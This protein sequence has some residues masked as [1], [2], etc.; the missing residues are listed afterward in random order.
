[1]TAEVRS[2]G[3]DGTKQNKICDTYVALDLETTGLNPKEDSIIE[4]G[5]VKVIGGKAADTY[6]AFVSPAKQLSERVSKLTGITQKDLEQAVQPEQAVSEILDFIGELPL[7]GHR[8][9]FDFSFLKRAAVNQ[10]LSFEK[11]GID[12]LRI[13]R[14]VLPELPSKRLEALCGHYGISYR[15]HRAYEDAAATVKLYEKLTE[16]F[17]R[18]ETAEIFRPAKLIYKVKR[19]S[20]A[21]KH[22]KER[23]RELIERHGLTVDY[24]VDKLTRNQA[25]RYMDKIWEQYGR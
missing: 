1:M 23:L 12:T 19:E 14:C 9:L 6:S 4:I 18:E 15:A 7:L 25:S 10:K 2:T 16:Q 21:T 3:I 13:A 8:I 17:Y 24:D 11:E 22:Q 20:P 5:A